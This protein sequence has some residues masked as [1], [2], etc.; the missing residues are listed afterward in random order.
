[1]DNIAATFILVPQ[2]GGSAVCTKEKK[3]HRGEIENQKEKAKTA[4][5]TNVLHTGVVFREI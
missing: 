5:G 4:F 2:F 1:V 3:W